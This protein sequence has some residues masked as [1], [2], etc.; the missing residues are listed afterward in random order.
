MNKELSQFMN[1]SKNLNASEE[2]LDDFL[3]VLRQAQL[4][5][6]ISMEQFR[7]WTTGEGA[8][9]MQPWSE[10]FFAELRISIE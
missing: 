10:E 2:V 4:E 5:F 7:S 6:K 3:V 9:K 8:V 1:D